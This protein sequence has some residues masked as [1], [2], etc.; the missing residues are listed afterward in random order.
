MQS[1]DALSKTTEWSLFIPRQT[2]Q[3]HGN[4]SLCPDLLCWRSCSWMVLWR[5]TRPSRTNTQKD[6]LLITGD[7]NEK[8]GSQETAGATGKFDLG[9][10]NETGQRVTE[11]CQENTLV[12][13][14]TLFQ[15]HKRRCYTCISRG[16][17]WN[18]IDYILGSQRWRCSIR[19]AK[20]RSR[21]DCGS[22]YEL[23]IAK[24]RLILKKVR[25]TTRPFRYDLCQIPYDYPVEVT[26]R[27]SGLYLID[28]VSDELQTEIH[29]I[30]QETEIK[31]ILKKKKYKKAKWL[32]EEALQ[33]AVKRREAKSKGEKERYT[34]MNA[35]FQRIAKRDKKKPS[36]V[37][38]AKK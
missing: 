11:F 4:P 18:Q 13:A 37:I 5:P 32:S 9:V 38:I 10:R 30:V 34:H 14:N 35:A 22:D 17:Y 24:L 16:Q 21:A 19:S 3:Y 6:I 28:R 36:S 1:L 2:I 25:K 27:F 31:T 12:I 26:N 20:T 7:W 23:C 29:D 15:Q 33:I 8:V